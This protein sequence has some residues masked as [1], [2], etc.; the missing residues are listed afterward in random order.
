MVKSVKGHKMALKVK[1]TKDISGVVCLYFSL[2]GLEITFGE[3]LLRM[4]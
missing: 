1:G 4:I 3:H 2:I